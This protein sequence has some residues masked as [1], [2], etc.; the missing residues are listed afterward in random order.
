MV[1]RSADLQVRIMGARSHVHMSK[2]AGPRSQKTR[3]WSGAPY[4][5]AFAGT[6]VGS[7]GAAAGGGGAAGGATAVVDTALGMG[8][9][10]G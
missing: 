3:H 8:M 1:F 9:A 4:S 7:A 6:G 10:N 5:A 2:A